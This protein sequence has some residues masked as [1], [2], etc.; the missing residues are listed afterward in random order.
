M[1]ERALYYY[2]EN[3]KY[4]YEGNMVTKAFLIKCVAIFRYWKGGGTAN[5]SLSHSACT[6]LVHIK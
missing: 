6:T 3:L 1:I 2:S 4:L 5:L